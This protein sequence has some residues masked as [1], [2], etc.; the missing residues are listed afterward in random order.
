MRQVGCERRQRSSDR[1]HCLRRRLRSLSRL[2]RRLRSLSCRHGSLRHRLRCR[3]IVHVARALLRP[4]TPPPPPPL[5]VGRHPVT[6]PV[7][8]APLS[9]WGLA[10]HTP[11][12]GGAARAAAA[13]ASAPPFVAPEPEDVRSVHHPPRCCRSRRR[14]VCPPPLL[15]ATASFPAA[16]A[17][18]PPLPA[19]AEA[20][21]PPRSQLAQVEGGGGA[22]SGG[23][24][25]GRNSRGWWRLAITP[26]LRLNEVVVVVELRRLEVRVVRRVAWPQRV[27]EPEPVSILGA[28]G[29]LA[30]GGLYVSQLMQT[31]PQ[32][33][34]LFFVS[35]T[36]TSWVLISTATLCVAA[37]GCSASC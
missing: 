25:S 17:P 27:H 30:K 37:W 5:L 28:S 20:G 36:I 11:G 10:S 23:P 31:P 1:L 21:H 4:S 16:A 15:W 24:A 32:R 33:F 26:R 12:V 8:P 7:R 13:A 3:R 2:R 19:P 29:H 22:G 9:A 14:V 18:A 34:P 35:W 6:A